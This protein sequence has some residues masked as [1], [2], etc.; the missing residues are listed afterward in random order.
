MNVSTTLKEIH[1]RGKYPWM[2]DAKIHGYLN[3]R[4]YLLKISTDI[5]HVTRDRNDIIVTMEST[6]QSVTIVMAATV[7][8]QFAQL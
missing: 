8:K 2:F 4:G 7:R 1:S 6:C 5:S 3:I